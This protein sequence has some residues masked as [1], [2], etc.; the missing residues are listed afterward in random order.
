VRKA[1]E[2]LGQKERKQQDI[3]DGCIMRGFVLHSNQMLLG[4]LYQGAWVWQEIKYT[5]TNEKKL[6]LRKIEGKR[7]V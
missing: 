4:S 2:D 7:Q 1:S 6:F 3:G 5:C